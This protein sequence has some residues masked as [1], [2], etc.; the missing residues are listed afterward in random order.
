[1]DCDGLVR[2]AG[3]A[4][5]PVQFVANTTSS[6]RNKQLEGRDPHQPRYRHRQQ[7]Q[8]QQQ[9]QRQRTATSARD[10]HASSING[11]VTSP[12]PP[13]PSLVRHMADSTD[14]VSRQSESSLRY[15]DTTTDVRPLTLSRRPERDR[16]SR[17][18]ARPSDDRTRARVQ[19][20]TRR[21]TSLGG[22]D[23]LRRSLVT[24]SGGTGGSYSSGDDSGDDIILQTRRSSSTHC[25]GQITSHHSHHITDCTAAKPTLLLMPNSTTRTPATDMLYNTTNGQAHNKL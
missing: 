13:Q 1:M 3:A 5:I 24:L 7:P 17:Q 18:R 16:R 8:Q 22:R 6:S 11:R 10:N 2:S 19:S 21:T 12:P 15:S 25:P 23:S 9:Q 4:H 14:T 20:D